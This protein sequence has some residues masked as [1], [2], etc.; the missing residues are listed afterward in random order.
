MRF[1]LAA[2]LAELAQLLVRV[3]DPAAEVVGADGERLLREL[4]AAA[5]L[6]QL[7]TQS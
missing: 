6:A 3:G 4:G 2:T 5:L 1:E 7:G